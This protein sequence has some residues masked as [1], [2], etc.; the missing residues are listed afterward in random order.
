MEML[1]KPVASD[2]V[3]VTFITSLSEVYG[4]IGIMRKVDG[5]FGQIYGK[6]PVTRC[7]DGCPASHFTFHFDF[8]TF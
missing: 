4:I 1:P 8:V 2:I 5:I 3:I 7:C 6:L